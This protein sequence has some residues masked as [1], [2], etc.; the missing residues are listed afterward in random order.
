MGR[1]KGKERRSILSLLIAAIAIGTVAGLPAATTDNLQ[2]LASNGGSLMIGDK[3]FSNFSFFE[4]GLTSFDPSKIQVTAS[5]SNGV[6][7]LTWDGNMS[8][9][10]SNGSGPASADLVLKY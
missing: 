5:V 10:T 3:T 7:Y 1:L 4:S 2:D 9:V 6:Y 8:L